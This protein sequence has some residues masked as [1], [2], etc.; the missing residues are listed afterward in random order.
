M[1]WTHERPR[2]GHYVPVDVAVIA[3]NACSSYVKQKHRFSALE[4]RI[5]RTVVSVTRFV[6]LLLVHY[7]LQL[8]LRIQ[9]T[10]F[11]K[12]TIII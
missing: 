12:I 4:E 9:N 7:I 1:Q 6:D 5:S 3:S 11:L 10:D 2:S 8:G